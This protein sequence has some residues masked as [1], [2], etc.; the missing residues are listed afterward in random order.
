MDV[1][2]QAATLTREQLVSLK[3]ILARHPGPVP[4]FLHFLHAPEEASLAL[5]RELGLTPSP[6]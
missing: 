5:P 2:L 3:R 4:V 6:E 1:R